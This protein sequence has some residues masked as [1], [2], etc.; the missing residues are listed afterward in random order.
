MAADILLILGT[1]LSIWD[2]KEKN[3][4]LDKYLALKEQYHQEFNKPDDSRSD[5]LLDNLEYQLRL[6]GREWSSAASGT[7][8]SGTPAG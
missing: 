2:H 6:L 5:S 4:Y 8:N 3:K 7:S 1:A